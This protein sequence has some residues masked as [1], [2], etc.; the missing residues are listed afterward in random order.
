MSSG[1]AWAVGSGHVCRD[2]YQIPGTTRLVLSF[3]PRVVNTWDSIPRKK[4]GHVVTTASPTEGHQNMANPRTRCFAQRCFVITLMR[5]HRN[6]ILVY[7]SEPRV[8]LFSL[9]VVS[10]KVAGLA[11][12]LSGDLLYWLRLSRKYLQCVCCV[13][14]TGEP[15]GPSPSP[16]CDRYTRVSSSWQWTCT[17]LTRSLFTGWAA[18]CLS[19]W[20]F[21]KTYCTWQI[22]RSARKPRRKVP[23]HKTLLHHMGERSRW[24][25][26][27]K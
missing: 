4:P 22:R 6:L 20:S 19:P 21:S 26:Q 1:H 5:C 8:K 15:W 3:C 2:N 16:L 17:Q 18:T 13:L 14:G 10:L 24:G 27:L 9:N 12:T 11:M 25:V 7:I 23:A